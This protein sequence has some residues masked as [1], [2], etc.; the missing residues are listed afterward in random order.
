MLLSIN[1]FTFS[2]DVGEIIVSYLVNFIDV[3]GCRLVSLIAL[4]FIAFYLYVFG[5]WSCAMIL[6]DLY[7]FSNWTA[8]S[9]NRPSEPFNGPQEKPFNVFEAFAAAKGG[10]NNRSNG[11]K[12]YE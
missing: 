4:K 5:E 2:S 9:C 6:Y 1:F 12:Q 11:R 8:F 10:L 7:Q 3:D